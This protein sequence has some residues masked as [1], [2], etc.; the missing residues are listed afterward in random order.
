MIPNRGARE[1][2]VEKI[3]YRRLYEEILEQLTFK[4]ESGELLPGS[5]LPTERELTQQF[6]VSRGT[7]R[8]AFRIL[9]NNGLI[10]SKPGGGRVVSD[11]YNL[12][13]SF[14]NLN[15]SLS[16]ATLR[17]LF[18][19]RII[20]DPIVAELAAIRA[21]DDDIDR[22]QQAMKK[23]VDQ[24][25]NVAVMDEDYLHMVL[26]ETTHN[27]LLIEMT[28]LNLDLVDRFRDPDISHN[29]YMIIE[30][31]AI[32][33]A[34]INRDPKAARNAMYTHLKN[35]ADRRNIEIDQMLGYKENDK[36]Q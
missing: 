19:F 9:E 24:S 27:L 31:Q 20:V 4:I 21:S 36:N 15:D 6:G 10:I 32:A 13:E 35:A 11:S 8:E 23:M 17:D 33:D 2:K 5:L 7:L 30:H 28:K 26:A 29:P 18:E 1:I 3:A 12:N 34:V 16:Q 25:G 22:V 14:S